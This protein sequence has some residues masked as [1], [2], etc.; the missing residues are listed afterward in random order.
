MTRVRHLIFRVVVFV[1]G[2]ALL[3]P[4]PMLA[5]MFTGAAAALPPSTGLVSAT[6]TGFQIPNLFESQMSVTDSAGNV[7]VGGTFS[8][9]STWA[10]G[11][12]TLT[13]AT[14]GLSDGAIVKLAPDGSVVWAQRYGGTAADWF[15]QVIIDPNNGQV[16]VAGSFARTASFGSGASFSLHDA[17]G[18]GNEG[19]VARFDPDGAFLSLFTVADAQVKAVA[20][21]STGKTVLAGTGAAIVVGTGA[22]AITVP[23][24]SSPPNNGFLAVIDATGTPVW[25]KP[26]VGST[27]LRPSMVATGPTGTVFIAGVA[28][29]ALTFGDPGN[30]VTLNA[31]AGQENDFVASYS[32]FGAFGWVRAVTSSA[33]LY[34]S[35]IAGDPNGGVL[36]LGYFY[37]TAQVSTGGVPV[38]LTQVDPSGNDAY[39]VHFDATGGLH[40]ATTFQDAGSAAPWVPVVDAAGNVFVAGSTTAQNPFSIGRDGRRMVMDTGG[41][42]QGFLVKFDA[43]DDVLWV[44]GG[45][46]TGSDFFS[47]LRLPDG[48]N[49]V[50]AAYVEAP[51]GTFGEGAQQV[52]LAAGRYDLTYGTFQPNRPPT[53]TDLHLGTPMNVALAVSVVGAD[54]DF[55]GLTF[56]HGAPAHGTVTGSGANLTYTPTTGYVGADAFSVSG[57]DGRG[58]TSS[59][60]VSVNVSPL[61]TAA[62]GVRWATGM[63][64]GTPYDPAIK[65]V[66]TDPYGNTIVA[67][68][69]SVG[70]TIGL[71]YNPVTLDRTAAMVAKY[72]MSGNLLWAQRASTSDATDVATDASGNV[73]LLGTFSNSIT[74]GEGT[75]AAVTF[76]HAG[77]AMFLAKYSSSGVLQWARTTTGL[78]STTGAAVAVDGAGNAY[79]T[80]YFDATGSA[81]F[82]TVN[83]TSVGNTDVFLV[84]YAPAGGVWWAVK[85]GG[86]SWDYADDV[87][88]S[89]AGNP[90]IVGAFSNTATFGTGATTFTLS[91]GGSSGQYVARYTAAGVAKWAQ[92]ITGSAYVQAV[93]ADTTGVYVS[94]SVQSTVVVGS[95]PTATTLVSTGTS[96][97]PLI[98]RFD[99]VA[100]SVSWARAANVQGNAFAVSADAGGRVFVAGQVSGAGAFGARP[101]AP[102]AAVNAF[103]ARYD[104]LGTAGWVRTV[105]GSTSTASGVALDGAG[106]PRLVGSSGASPT[107]GDTSSIVVSQTSGAFIAAYGLNQPNRAPQM[108]DASYFGV[109][110]QP[111]AVAIAASDA[112]GDPLAFTV[113]GPSPAHG[114]VSGS[115]PTF[116]YTPVTGYTGVDSFGLTVNDGNGGSAHATVTVRINAPPPG[117]LVARHVSEAVPTAQAVDG[118]RNTFTVGRFVESV[119]LGEGPAAVTLTWDPGSLTTGDGDGFVAK[120]DPHGRLMWAQRFGGID[121][122]A[123]HGATT[124]A[125]GNVVVVGL[126]DWTT[127]FGE[128]AGAMTLTGGYHTP[129]MAKYAADGTFLWAR[130]IGGG[131][132]FRELATVID[133]SGSIF[134]RGRAF[135]SVVI[136][137][138]APISLPS[139]TTSTMEAFVARFDASGTAMWAQRLRDQNGTNIA[140]M[141][142]DGSGALV[143]GGSFG[144]SMVIG[145]GAQQMTIVGTTPGLVSNPY[146]YLARFDSAGVLMS[147]AEVGRATPSGLGADGAGNIYLA[148]Y[149]NTA[150][151]IG[152]GA[153]AVAL[154]GSGSQ[155]VFVARF[156]ATFSIAWARS[157]GG[158]GGVTTPVMAVDGAGQLFLASS[159]SGTI[160]FQPPLALTAPSYSDTFL[161]RFDNAGNVLSATSDGGPSYDTVSSVALDSFGNAHVVGGFTQSATF[162]EGPSPITISA[163][164]P[165]NPEGFLAIYGATAV[166]ADQVLVTDAGSPLTITLS[167]QDGDGSA[168]SFTVSSL[169]SHG[170]LAGTPPSLSYVSD[171]GYSGPDAF[172][173]SA[174]DGT[175]HPDVGRVDIRVVGL[176]TAGSGLLWARALV[177][178]PALTSTS[179]TVD[180]AG[181]ATVTGCFA[182][183]LGVSDPSGLVTTL[184]SVGGSMDAAIVQYS[185][186]GYVLWARSAGGVGADCAQ[187]VAVDDAGVMFVTGTFGRGGSGGVAATFGS[188]PGAVTLTSAGDD[189]VFVASYDVSGALRWVVKAGGA[190]PDQVKGI[191]TAGGKVVVAGAVQGAASFGVGGGLVTLNPSSVSTINGAFVASYDATDGTFGWVQGAPST[192]SSVATGVAIGQAGQ[193][194]VSGTASGSTTFAAGAG[195]TIVSIGSSDGFVA[196]YDSAG[197]VQWVRQVGSV[198]ADTAEGVAVGPSGEAYLAGAF[199]V[200]TMFGASAG[201]LELTSAG[202][203]D[204]YLARYSPSGVLAFVRVVGG[205]QGD[206]ITDVSTDGAGHVVVVGS[207]TETADVAGTTSSAKL[208]SRGGVDGF[209]ARFDTTG[210]L[211]WA[212]SAGGSG[213]DGMVAVALD[214]AGNAR[215]VGTFGAGGVLGDG[216]NTYSTST[217]SASYVA[218][219]GVDQADQVPALAPVTA[220]VVQG[221]PVTIPLTGGDPDGDVLFVE[222][223][224]ARESHGISTLAGMTLTY[225]SM[226][227][228]GVDTFSVIVHDGRGGSATATVT[229]TVTPAAVPPASL[230]MSAKSVSGSPAAAASA[231]N[232]AGERYMV[233]SFST[234]TTFGAGTTRMTTLVSDG[235]KVGFVAKYRSDGALVW[236]RRI[237]G[238]T[239]S[240]TAAGLALDSAGNPIVVGS[241]SGAATFEDGDQTITIAST[242]TSHAFV[243]SYAGDGTPSFARLSSGAGTAAAQGVAVDQTGSIVVAGTFTAP[244]TFDGGLTSVSLTSAGSSDQY[245]ARFDASGTLLW[246]QSAG[247][248]S[249]DSAEA[250][251]VSPDGSISVAGRLGAAGAFGTGPDRTI[252]WAAGPAIARYTADGTFAWVRRVGGNVTAL[253][254]G[255][256]VDEE[257]SVYVT[258]SFAGTALFGNGSTT[259][260]TSVSTSDDAFIVKFAASGLVQWAQA[261]GG[262]SADRG[263]AVT[264]DPSGLPIVVGTFAGTATFG[265]GASAVSLTSLGSDDAFVVRLTGG[266]VLVSASSFGGVGSDSVSAVAVAPTG[267]H[268]IS[269]SSSSNPLV[270]PVGGLLSVTNGGRPFGFVIAVPVTAE[271]LSGDI[272]S[273]PA[274]PLSGIVVRAHDSSGRLVGTTRSRADGSYRLT[275]LPPG[276]YR[277]RFSDPLATYADEWYDDAPNLFVASDVTVAPATVHAGVDAT[278]ATVA[279]LATITGS[280]NG[281]GGPLGAMQVSLYTASGTYVRSTMTDYTSAFAFAG[282]APGSYVVSASDPAAVHPTRW[283]IDATTMGAA[284]AIVATAATTTP[285]IDIVLP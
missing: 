156:G 234:A 168:V 61:P 11:T 232:A 167:A 233:G 42:R 20:V 279:S 195:Q 71:P 266:G 34:G 229:V 76:N 37:D 63:T 265:Q 271:G 7:Y 164:P 112:D 126:F 270:F 40:G 120:Y 182:G 224:R 175:G 135:G 21:D 18:T 251:A 155:V 73:F 115:G 140:G 278:L 285:N 250:V 196:S 253:D 68:T 62:S 236:V 159:F 138:A 205:T 116:A 269:G 23:G 174:D 139:T 39:L 221:A 245:L 163:I 254:R 252:L 84:K 104:T 248:G 275:S 16:I 237:E 219:L 282:V 148:G 260:L 256:A 179:L 225:T 35:T 142:V 33:D 239:G 28:M 261:F 92:P 107:F 69:S 105:G 280:V 157:L 228:S 207:F 110:D 87:A 94:G 206:T 263:A 43:N 4:L 277:V 91:A 17:R 50:V 127:T 274:S 204:G 259:K 74:L 124:D 189:D 86:T 276:S 25:A 146:A 226:T 67:G 123:A 66:A 102:V 244:Q 54:P 181:R 217:A 203:T 198:A 235:S 192:V 8:A 197:G 230:A 64:G 190:R 58:G 10:W 80:G 208:V 264:V 22:G 52:T 129:F 45:G 201:A 47:N 222:V 268:L 273:G 176:P 231:A 223:D 132:Q 187:R 242:T 149:F 46:G 15:S 119:M 240:A 180:A 79:V 227:F 158:S 65:Q 106:N 41:T 151:T 12:N 131:N 30:Q 83:L 211:A 44:R 143:I 70:A 93:A 137:D 101:V 48:V 145:S 2:V 283:W 172:T 5:P 178:S 24:G 247:G 49:P 153:G 51:G 218:S 144:R 183:T 53:L 177:A 210:A 136:G 121:D 113:G 3:L 246:A 9:T 36:M 122:D 220:S 88:V 114:S 241:V 191:S 161:A 216:G 193:V 19:F 186:D 212:R 257:G 255:L 133:A 60:T 272:T 90:T 118:A 96:T 109:L 160:T 128:G 85:A 141:K 173:F 81:T 117:V 147:A 262:P 258:G 38:T 281:P 77:T 165:A 214:P 169:P 162:G 55:D 82:A 209:I 27:F 215:L 150:A 267:D 166:A 98:A 29:G 171:A 238:S 13:L 111:V 100:G 97:N 249:T 130:A 170:V 59:A 1:F 200:T 57:D 99:D 6:A 184:T 103:L 284:T 188:G 32:A 95:G 56:S 213:T 14:V 154:S 75:A 31:A 108:V 89:T 26:V 152:S 134:V 185:I 199:R 202:G 78:A 243:V 72:D 194:F 125:A